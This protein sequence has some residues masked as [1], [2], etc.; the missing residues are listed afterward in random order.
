MIL[1]CPDRAAIVY[2]RVF[3]TI[4]NYIEGQISK[5]TALGRLCYEKPDN[6]ICILNQQLI[7]EYLSF[8]ECKIVKVYDRCI[9]VE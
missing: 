3:D 2:D 6:Q 4:E 8:E 9:S 7:D 5:D 1:R